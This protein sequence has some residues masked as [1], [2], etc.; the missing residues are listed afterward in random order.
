MYVKHWVVR[1]KFTKL[2]QFGKIIT[3]SYQINGILFSSKTIDIQFIDISGT[4]VP[5]RYELRYCYELK[6]T[7]LKLM[8]YKR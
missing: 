5:R 6:I 3:Q 4:L 1:L 2:T 8:S 7:Q